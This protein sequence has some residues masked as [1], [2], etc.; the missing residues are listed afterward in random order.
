MTNWIGSQTEP[1]GYSKPPIPH[2]GWWYL[3]PS[4]WE[5]RQHSRLLSLLGHPVSSTQLELTETGPPCFKDGQAWSGAQASDL[6]ML[7]TSPSLDQHCLINSLHTDCPLGVSFSGTWSKKWFQLDS[8]CR[9]EEI[10]VWCQLCSCHYA[11][12]HYLSANVC[13][14]MSDACM[15]FHFLW[16]QLPG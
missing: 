10:N 8:Q 12:F 15:E 13:L 1:S 16:L 9:T 2:L 11:Q 3:F 5:F 6:P 7:S 4:S 14:P